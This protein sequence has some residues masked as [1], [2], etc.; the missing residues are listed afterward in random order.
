MLYQ[1]NIPGKFFTLLWIH[2]AHLFYREKADAISLYISGQ[3]FC[4]PSIELE[5]E[6]RNF[7]FLHSAPMKM[8]LY[9]LASIYLA[10]T[11]VTGLVL[12]R[13]CTVQTFSCPCG[14]SIGFGATGLGKVRVASCV[15]NG[16][17]SKDVCSSEAARAKCHEIQGLLQ[18]L[19]RFFSQ[20]LLQFS[21]FFNPFQKLNESCRF[22]CRV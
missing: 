12:K 13:N 15:T 16:S 2:A 3:L 8:L 22:S 14:Q 21:F 17:H 5:F 9:T 18:D 7:S 6:D 19:A 10:N 1:D 4:C 11:C 20:L